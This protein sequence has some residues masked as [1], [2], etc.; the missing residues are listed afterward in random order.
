VEEYVEG[1]EPYRSRG[2]A[3]EDE[4][5]MRLERARESDGRD[6]HAHRARRPISSTMNARPADI[7]DTEPQRL[8]FLVAAA[9]EIETDGSGTA[10]VAIHV[11]RL[12][13]RHLVRAVMVTK[14]GWIE[15]ARAGTATRKIDIE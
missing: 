15:L 7:S 4:E 2:S 12:R 14:S 8:S 10:G 3:F 11:E 5:K 6:V 1:N 9:M 13:L